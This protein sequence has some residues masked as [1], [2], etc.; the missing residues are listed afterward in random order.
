MCFYSMTGYGILFFGFKLKLVNL[1]YASGRSLYILINGYLKF[2][3]SYKEHETSK[4][5]ELSNLIFFTITRLSDPYLEFHMR[6]LSIPEIQ[7]DV[8]PKAFRHHSRHPKGF[9]RNFKGAI[10]KTE[11][12]KLFNLFQSCIDFGFFIRN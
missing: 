3:L 1:V 7:V 5:I 10:P 8:V 9:D 6:L 2:R 12:E 4:S 11:Y